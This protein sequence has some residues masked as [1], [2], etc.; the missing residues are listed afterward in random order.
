LICGSS[1]SSSAF[2]E[3]ETTVKTSH[4]N[5]PIRANKKIERNIKDPTKIIAKAILSVSYVN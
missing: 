3:I 1:L 5:P 4:T 2:K